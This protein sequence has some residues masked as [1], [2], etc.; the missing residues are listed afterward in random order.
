MAQ[1]PYTRREHYEATDSG[2]MRFAAHTVLWGH[3]PKD[4]ERIFDVIVAAGYQGVELFQHP[5]KLG[6]PARIL[7]MLR[8]RNLELLG[9]CS[10]SPDKRI[11]W[12]EQGAGEEAWFDARSPYLYM[13]GFPKNGFEHYLEKGWKLALHPYSLKQDWSFD[14]VITKL[15]ALKKY[16][17]LLYLPDTAHAAI[18]RHNIIDS[19]KEFRHRLAAV[20]LKDW[21]PGYGRASGRYAIGFTEIGRGVVDFET[22]FKELLL[23]AYS[24]LW[25]VYEQNYSEG[26][27]DQSLRTSS[28]ALY[29]K[30]VGLKPR[31]KVT[32]KH[33][34]ATSHFSGMPPL[35]LVRRFSSARLASASIAQLYLRLAQ[36]LRKCL[37]LKAVAIWSCSEIDLVKTL[38][39]VSTD[40]EDSDPTFEPGAAPST[41]SPD[42]RRVASDVTG[43]GPRPLPDKDLLPELK[44]LFLSEGEPWAFR[45]PV[46]AT[47]NPYRTRIIVDLGFKTNRSRTVFK[48]NLDFRTELAEAII[49]SLDWHLETIMSSAASDLNLSADKAKDLKEFGERL[50]TV[51]QDRMCCEHVSLFLSDL[52]GHRLRPFVSDDLQWCTKAE[53]DRYYEPD[54]GQETTQVWLSLRPRF[55]GR[56]TQPKPGSL[57]SKSWAPG[58][59]PESQRALLMPIVDTAGN[60]IGVIRCVNKITSEGRLCNFGD[61]DLLVLDYMMQHA[62]PTLRKLQAAEEERARNLIVAHELKRPVSALCVAAD[63]LQVE[64]IEDDKMRMLVSEYVMRQVKHVNRFADTLRILVSRSAF[65]GGHR[66]KQFVASRRHT[67]FMQEIVA[68]VIKLLRFDLEDNKLNPGHLRYEGFHELPPLYIDKDMFHQIVFNLLDNAIKYARPAPQDFWV[69]VSASNKNDGMFTIRFKDKGIGIPVELRELIFDLG[70][71]GP[72]AHF[73]SAGSGIGLWLVRE[74]LRLHGARIVIEDDP[75]FTV[76]RIDLPSGLADRSWKP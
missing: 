4:F 16:V 27:R 51:I 71:R 61:D 62:L 25:V 17:N 66:D 67:R 29:V 34:D 22:L 2:S 18:Q 60:S 19:V 14:D 32:P 11:E 37:D 75:Q 44:N 8:E 1:K 52:G 36:E 20:H 31:A 21:R 55:D 35:D 53:A 9:L 26:M 45:F 43:L 48:E 70:R 5:Q 49:H 24:R 47:W 15:R 69:E 41:L 76:F 12:L 38:Q 57:N 68:P 63:L 23:P 30:K 54:D 58:S 46:R 28:D 3:S 7:R 59:D 50:K 33:Y 6:Q 39:G 73:H 10:G 42:L 40:A 72:E 64:F 56:L 74:L 65:F 13:D